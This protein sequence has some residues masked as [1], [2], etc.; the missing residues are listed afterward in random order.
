MPNQYVGE[1][2]FG[3]RLLG[4]FEGLMDKLV[5]CPECS[6]ATINMY[7]NGECQ[8]RSCGLKYNKARLSAEEKLANTANKI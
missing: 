2:P 6:A 4:K 5:I 8:C 7:A 3:S 1:K